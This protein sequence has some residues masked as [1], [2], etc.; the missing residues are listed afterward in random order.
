MTN[1][2]NKKKIN[3]KQANRISLLISIIYFI[4]MFINGLILK[5]DGNFAVYYW[6]IG[7]VL[8][9]IFIYFVF[10]VFV[11]KVEDKKN[12]EEE[13]K[14][15]FT[16]K[17]YLSNSDYKQVYFLYKN[18]D[19][20]KP[21]PAEQIEDIHSRGKI[22]PAEKVKEWESLDLCAP[23]DAIGSASWR[24]K[25]FRHSCH[26]CLVDYASNHE[27]YTSMFQDIKIVKPK[28]HNDN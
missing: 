20:I 2:R 22:T 28:I 17:Q 10:Y 16:I 27:E 11:F 6:T 1:N 9:T 12:T 19:D 14:I 13:Q 5:P 21:L 23:G 4:Y 26:D 25:K 18:C 7:L 15:E 8:G 3:S 24:C